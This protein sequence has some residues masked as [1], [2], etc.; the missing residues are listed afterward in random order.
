[1]LKLLISIYYTHIIYGNKNELGDCSIPYTSGYVHLPPQAHDI[2]SF[3]T[4]SLKKIPFHAD[5]PHPT[6]AQVA[7]LDLSPRTGICCLSVAQ[8]SAEPLCA[9]IADHQ[10]LYHY[11]LKTFV[12]LGE[13]RIIRNYIYVPQSWFQSSAWREMGT[14]P[15]AFPL[16]IFLHS[17]PSFHSCLPSSYKAPDLC[18]SSVHGKR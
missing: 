16:G 3:I 14:F 7:P 9:C 1:M 12:F 17:V 4:S 18:S 13:L 5:I 15:E 10:P 8:I 11:K 6:T 2:C